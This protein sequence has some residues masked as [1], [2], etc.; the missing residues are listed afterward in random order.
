MNSLILF[1]FLKI[2]LKI[3]LF[4]QKL[5][6]KFDDQKLH[7]NTAEIHELICFVMR[8]ENIQNIVFSRISQ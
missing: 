2:T 7:Q 4:H 6:K 5:T 3:L 1:I 8:F